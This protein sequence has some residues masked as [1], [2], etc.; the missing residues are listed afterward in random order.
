MEGWD[1]GEWS[2]KSWWNSRLMVSFILNNYLFLFSFQKLQPILRSCPSPHLYTAG[3]PET[4]Y[5]PGTTSPT[6][7][8][9]FGSVRVAST[10]RMPRSTF[11]SVAGLKTR[12]PS[13]WA[14]SWYRYQLL[15]WL[16][17]TIPFCFSRVWPPSAGCPKSSVAYSHYSNWASWSQG[18]GGALCVWIIPLYRLHWQNT[19]LFRGFSFQPC[20]QA[21]GLELGSSQTRSHIFLFFIKF[22]F[23]MKY[24][25]FTMLCQSL[26]CSKA[27]QL[28]SYKHY[29]YSSPLWLITGH[30]IVSCA[31][32]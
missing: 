29:L 18:V 27:I 10:M 30:W 19:Q 17:P 20:D 28:C 31:I 3:R 23:L 13:W 9:H 25:W 26:L 14:S 2:L 11:T 7:Q 12:S 16:S 4:C 1:R 22:Y 15:H 24:S 6:R 32:Q 8:R 21:H 5:L